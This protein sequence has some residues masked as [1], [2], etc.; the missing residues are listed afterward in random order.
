MTKIRAWTE[1]YVT[2]LV[3][4]HSSH[5]PIKNIVAR[6]LFR[7]RRYHPRISLEI[8]QLLSQ[9][10]LMQLYIKLKARNNNRR[11]ECSQQKKKKKKKKLFN[12]SFVPFPMVLF[13]LTLYQPF[14]SQTA[15]YAVEISCTCCCV[16]LA[17]GGTHC[18]AVWIV[19]S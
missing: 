5:S 2:K 3:A 12:C 10:M 9:Q 16:Y 14:G 18:L 6:Q 1:I 17:S 11:K 7:N 15:P 4:C 19:R 8:D 13:H